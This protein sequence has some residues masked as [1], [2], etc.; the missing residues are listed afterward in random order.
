MGGPPSPFL[1]ASPYDTCTKP[2]HSGTIVLHCDLT[3][4]IVKETANFS[5]LAVQDLVVA[6]PVLVCT[7]KRARA[8]CNPDNGASMEPLPSVP[9]R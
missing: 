1:Q 5:A 8:L 9:W 3:W 7:L 2:C 6:R 4:K